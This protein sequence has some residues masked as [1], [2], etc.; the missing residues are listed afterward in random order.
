MNAKPHTYQRHNESKREG[1]PLITGQEDLP[2][3][4][5]NLITLSLLDLYTPSECSGQDGLHGEPAV[6]STD[7]RGNLHNWHVDM[8]IGFVYKI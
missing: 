6:H 3:S 1:I 5:N 7:N 4:L 2:G 8:Y